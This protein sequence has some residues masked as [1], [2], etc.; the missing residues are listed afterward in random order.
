[1]VVS[2]IGDLARGYQNRLANL[3]LKKDIQ[4]LSQELT[5]G[6]VRDV[7]GT[8]GRDLGIL[9]D[10][11]MRL[12]ALET[13]RIAAKEA[14]LH[15]S[16]VQAA[17]TTMRE[18][19]ER[20]GAALV[21]AGTAGEPS[22][23]QAAATDARAGL[24]AV[25]AAL[26][27][28]VADRTVF[29]GVAVSG[30]AV[31]DGESLLAA[32]EAEIAGETTAGAILSRVDAWFDS[33]G[34][35]FETLGYLGADTPLAPFEVGPGRQAEMSVTAAD[36]EIREVLKGYALAGLLA[37]GALSAAPEERAALG[38]IAGERILGA[39]GALAHVS[40]RIGQAEAQ[41][42]EASV[43]NEAE[44][45]ALEIARADLLSVDPYRTASALQ[46]VQGRLEALYAITSRLGRLSLAEY[47]R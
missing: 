18:A 26:N 8:L 2:S 34:G 24:D 47:L 33:P 12:K 20:N 14:A 28:R 13:H 37:R 19:G 23:L 41:V 16:V 29:A 1:M 40:A 10:V 21:Q 5:T 22:W 4:A 30:P 27:T 7:S 6:T 15:G 3:R 31:A 9:S 25:I 17:L 11:E 39:T 43:A 45:T 32:L 44:Q 36:R 46:E 35:G 42:E 38:R